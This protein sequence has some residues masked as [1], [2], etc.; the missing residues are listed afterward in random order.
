M[1]ANRTTYRPSFWARL[2]R[3]QSWKL[4]LNSANP[5]Q[6]QLNADSDVVIQT[7]D[8]SNISTRKGLIWNSVEIRSK[9][10]IDNLSGLNA[11]KAKTL[12]DDLLQFVNQFLAQIIESDKDNMSEIDRVLQSVTADARQ[13]LAHADVSRFISRVTGPVATA[14]SHPLFDMAL[15]KHLLSIAFPMSFAIITDPTTRHRYND[16]FVAKELLRYQTF[17]DDLGGMSLSDEQR[18]A[19]IRLEDNNLLIASAGSG[20]TATMVAKVAYVLQ[21]ELYRPDEILILAFNKAA[22]VELRERIAHQLG[23]AE[24]EL[25]CKVS[26]FHALGR[27]IIEQTEGHPPQLANWVEHP[28]GEAHVIEE[29]IQ[30]Q[31]DQSPEFLALW[32]ELLILFPKADRP[33]NSFQSDDEY[34]LYIA[35]RI[36]TDGDTVSTMS[37]V[38]VRSLQERAISNWLW[39]NSV[40]F[41][42]ERQFSVQDDFGVTRFVHPDFYYPQTKTVHEHFAIDKAGKSPFPN[43]VEHAQK[44]RDG[45]KR[46][47]IDFFET[48]SAMASD[49]TLLSQL[50]THL[51]KRGLRFS[52]RKQE[53]IDKAL[54]PTVIRRYHNL[55]S[56]C[57][58]HIRSSQLTLEMLLE[59]AKTLHDQARSRRF[60]HV[61]W[62]LAQAY[63]QRLKGIQRI[64]FESMIGNATRM[65][66]TGQFCSPYSLILVD[67]F[68]DISD[69]RANLIKALKHQR[70]FT[71]VFAVGDDWQSIYRFAGSDISIFT[72][73]HNHFGTSWRGKLQNTYRCNQL[74]ASTAASFVQRNPE[75]VFR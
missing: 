61:V 24:D 65:V 56:V 35:D 34:Q 19:S 38:Y 66:E 59:R 8:I 9:N 70:P 60:A 31:M 11:E 63:D 14:I 6:V 74:I 54:E 22:A 57:I 15:I 29:L 7:C 58:K 41:E 27:G 49:D 68:Q 3:L 69:S 33:P 26:T 12:S 39:L 5:S 18:E 16:D 17:F 52:R 30:E 28:S 50:H 10:R 44:K 55:I 48:T 45:Y 47:G 75:C 1:A 71:K 36:R 2:F 42:Y 23:V 37:G 40:A 4:T 51:Q 25:G 46:E 21:K 73:F 13:Y 20:K 53:E 72:S 67:E 43:Y 62:I 32:M 64:D